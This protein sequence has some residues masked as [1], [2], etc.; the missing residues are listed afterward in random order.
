MNAVIVMALDM[1]IQVVNIV[2]IQDT[3]YVQIV[4]TDIFMNLVVFAK[5]MDF[6]L[7]IKKFFAIKRKSVMNVRDL[8]LILIIIRHV[9][10][11]MELVKQYV[12]GV[13]EQALE[14]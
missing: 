11:V 14:S 1:C 12:F 6:I 5:E 9:I 4:I 13:M 10:N 8:A 3:L 7:N 2:I